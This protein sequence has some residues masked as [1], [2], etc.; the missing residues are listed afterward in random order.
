MWL[1][2][3]DQG[4]LLDNTGFVATGYTGDPQHLNQPTADNI[5]NCGPIP[6]GFWNIGQAQDHPKLGP[7]A[8]PLTPD[9]TTMTFGRSG[10][11]IHGDDIAAPGHGSEGCIVLPQAARKQIAA[12]TDRRLFAG[13]AL[14]I[15]LR[16]IAQE[17]DP[18]P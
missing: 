17:L 6:T 4:T 1:F 18:N 15:L 2:A 3:T 5:P 14:A 11:W 7:C 9:P 16:S 8:M 13:P 10:F 12:S